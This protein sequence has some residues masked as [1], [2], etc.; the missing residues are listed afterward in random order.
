MVHFLRTRPLLLRTAIAVVGIDIAVLFGFVWCALEQFA[1]C[2]NVVQGS[3]KS[4]DGTKAVFVFRHECNATVPDSI[5]AS[6]AA[7]DR[8]S[9][10]KSSTP[11]QQKAP[12]ITIPPTI[13]ALADHVIA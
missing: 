11:A 13:L 1:S 3:T 9:L 5:W 6:V 2:S 8:P 7:T 4:P 10:N 12:G